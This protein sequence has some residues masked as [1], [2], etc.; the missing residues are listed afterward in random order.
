MPIYGIV[1]RYPKENEELWATQAH[2]STDD[3]EGGYL[4]EFSEGNGWQQPVMTRKDLEFFQSRPK[5]YKVESVVNR[6]TRPQRPQP[7]EE[8]PLDGSAL[9][10]ERRTFPPESKP[11]ETKTVAVPGPAAEHPK[12]RPGRPP[13]TVEVEAPQK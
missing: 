5:D 12:K 13:R 2:D 11:V 8:K 6:P 4:Y 7:M 1:T 9:M 10:A 3:P